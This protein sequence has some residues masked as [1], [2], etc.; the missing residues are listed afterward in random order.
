MS[1]SPIYST[2]QASLASRGRVGELTERLQTAADE[3]ATGFKANPFEE[4][5]LRAAET[6]EIRNLRSR[7]ENFVT[8][9]EVLS[10]KLE[11]QDEALAAVSEEIESFLSLSIRSDGSK[12]QVSSTLQQEARAVLDSVTRIM[13][14][15]YAGEYVFSGIDTDTRPIQTLGEVNPNSGLAPDAVVDTILGGGLASAPD[16]V[17]KIGQLDDI[18]A[19]ATGTAQ[20]Y[21]A[22]FFNGTPLLDGGGTPNPRL[23]TL[24][25]DNE[26][27]QYGVQANDRAIRDALQGLMMFARVDTS[28]IADDGAYEAWVGAANDRLAS[29]LDGVTGM[30]IDTGN[31][32]AQV[33]DRIQLQQDRSDIYNER[34]LS[35]EGVDPYDAAT[36][37]ENL[38]GMVDATYAA[39]ARI[40]NL[41]FVN[42]L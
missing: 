39:T 8:T 33:K 31:D 41:S 42:Y 30:R 10:G 40:S 4:M 20:D 34:I 2:L 22:T 1:I 25:D 19:S 38:R 5:G 18:F 29:A 12:S 27:V 37:V 24:I 3:L 9:N 13:N 14:T 28:T 15:T 7:T 11:M 23:S 32:L 36:R 26:T 21:E 17:A 35:I 6:L 16:A